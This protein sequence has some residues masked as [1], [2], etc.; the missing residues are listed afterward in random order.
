M[1][2]SVATVLNENQSPT[3][4]DDFLDHLLPKVKTHARFRFRDLP[5]CER[6]E[7]EADTVAVALVFFVRLLARGKNPSAFAVRIA[8]IAVLRVKEGRIVGMRA[9]LFTILE[10]QFGSIPEKIRDEISA[11]DD[12]AEIDSLL[13]KAIH[14]TSI[15]E[16]SR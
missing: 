14:I 2:T 10:N 16:L 8:K 5:R 12:P 13:K 9:A 1:S 11:K 7:A 3:W 4:Q 6:E 15:D